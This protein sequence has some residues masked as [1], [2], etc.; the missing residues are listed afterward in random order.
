MEMF[1]LMVG[2]V[3]EVVTVVEI[4]GGGR[5]IDEASCLETET[6]EVR[7][8]EMEILP[9]GV[10]EEVRG[11]SFFWVAEDSFRFKIFLF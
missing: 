7:T 10:K 8:S 11:T 3:E 1:I 5:G 9:E 6:G 2:G 4:V